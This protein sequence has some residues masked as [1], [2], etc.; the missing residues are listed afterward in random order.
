MAVTKPDHVTLVL[1]G[2][3]ALG[4]YHAG[5]YAALHARRVEVDWV[6]GASIGAITGALIAGNAPEDRLA[7]LRAGWQPA[8]LATAWPEPVETGRRT[9]AA[10]F[11]AAFGRPGMFR[12]RGMLG[13]QSLLGTEDPS[14]FDTDPMLASLATLVDLARLN[15]GPV[16]FTATAVDLESGEDA[17]FDTQGQ[18]VTIDHVR[19]SGALPPLF[20]PIEIDGRTYVDA[21]VSANLPLDPYL[22][23]PP[24]GTAL[25]LAV[26]LLPL[27]APLP[28]RLGEVAGRAQDLMFAAQSRRTLTA[29]QRLYDARASAASITLVHLAYADQ[30]REVAGKALDF[31]PETIAD[32]WAAGERAMTRVLDRVESGEIALGR[33]GLAIETG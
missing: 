1:G 11:T 32:R 28:R 25:C 18:A 27:A 19:A 21:G 5:C 26:D 15:N 33:K 24:E 17:V 30:S 16:R 23:A 2:G 14:V 7:Q 8:G 22:S 4:A 29:W 3:N 9:L 31:S 20:P 13:W 10:T 12:H 6:I